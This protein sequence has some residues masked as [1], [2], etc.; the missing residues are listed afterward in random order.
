MG[1]RSAGAE[2]RPPQPSVVVKT[3]SKSA[4]GIVG[5]HFTRV[6]RAYEIF[7]EIAKR[8]EQN[9]DELV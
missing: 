8:F 5:S 9:V 7:S 1:G 4:D 2:I 3:G 6:N